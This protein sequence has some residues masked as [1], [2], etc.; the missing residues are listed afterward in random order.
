M[1]QLIIYLVVA[2]CS[3][4]VQSC[5]MDD[6]NCLRVDGPIET[7][8]RT[9]DNFTSVFF[10]DVGNLH[11]SQGNE[12]KVIL[13]AQKVILDKLKTK[14]SEG[15]ELILSL[16]ECFNGD[17]YS[18]DIYITVPEIEKIEMSGVGFVKTETAITSDIFT[19]I[20]NG[21]SE[22][23]ELNVNAD[24]ISTYLLGIGDLNYSG[25]S[26]VH[27]VLS[28]GTGN[29]NAYDLSTDGTYI[30]SNGSGNIYVTAENNLDAT[31]NSTGNVY[32]KGHP[33]VVKSENGQGKVVDDN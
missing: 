16:D 30:T 31:L 27:T 21:A 24:S 4:F 10:A 7:Q 28:S 20:L 13:K 33:K 14:V 5:N 17:A 6:I 9:L 8:K 26:R 15:G 25:N 23:N 18:L 11:I 29:I 12:Q 2:I 22:I 32:F 1:R 19:L 3:F